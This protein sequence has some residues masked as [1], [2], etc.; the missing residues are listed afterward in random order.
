MLTSLKQSKNHGG[1]AL[2]MYAGTFSSH[3][4]EAVNE[5]IAQVCG[6]VKICQSEELELQYE[7]S[8][9]EFE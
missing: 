2:K 4:S 3:L 6:L 5:H 9:S 7:N 8:D 1:Q